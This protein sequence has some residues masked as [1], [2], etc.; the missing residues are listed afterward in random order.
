MIPDKITFHTVNMGTDNAH[1]LAWISIEKDGFRF[2][3]M[4]LIRK[5]D[6]GLR[7]NFPRQDRVPEFQLYYPTSKDA[8]EVL[9]DFVSKSWAEF[10]ETGGE[11]F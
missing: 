10:N 8:Y 5:P 6:G 1:H 9:F 7:I 11:H 3:N 2:T 4:A